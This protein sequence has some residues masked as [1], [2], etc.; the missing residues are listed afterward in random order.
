MISTLEINLALHCAFKNWYQK[1]E[2]KSKTSLKGETVQSQV[3]TGKTTAA[4]KKRLN[5]EAKEP[6]TGR[7]PSPETSYRHGWN[8]EILATF[9]YATSTFQMGL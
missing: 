9:R 6:N 4:T 2:T 7:V 5:Q 1:R 8:Q 3:S